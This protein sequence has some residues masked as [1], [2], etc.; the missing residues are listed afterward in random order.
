MMAQRIYCPKCGQ[1]EDLDVLHEEAS[2]SE[3]TFEEVR[4]DYYAN[5]CKALAMLY[6][7]SVEDECRANQGNAARASASAAL[8]DLMGEDIDGVSA[9]ME[10][11]EYLGMFR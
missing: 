2:E 1:E 4:V 6:G 5:G 8:M 3:R 9:M 10:D 11:A 7:G